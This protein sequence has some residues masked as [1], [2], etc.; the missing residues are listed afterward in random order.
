MNAT[1][2]PISR[3]EADPFVMRHYLHRWPAIVHSVLGLRVEGA[4]QGV[5][6]FALPPRETN[7]RY[8]VAKSLELARLFVDDSQHCNTESWFLSRA[9]RWLK[10]THRDIEIL[11]SYADPS[12]N[13]LGKIYQAANWIADGR[14]DDDRKTPR[15][16]YVWNGNHYARRGHLPP[17]ADFER[18]PRVS[19]WRYVYPLRKP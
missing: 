10:R 15:C 19:K 1:V 18:V 5:I 7:K 4:L 8:H 17:G 9:V 6:V 2:E 11:V 3:E 14:T 16:D 13:H 12:V